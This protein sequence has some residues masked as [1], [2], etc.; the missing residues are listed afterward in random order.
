VRQALGDLPA[1]I[2]V[3]TQAVETLRRTENWLLIGMV[4]SKLGKAYLEQTKLQEAIMMLEQAL[5]IF[6]KERHADHESRALGAL[7]AAYGEMQQWSKSQEYREQALTLAREHG[8]QSE[9]AA[10]LPALAHL[11]EVQNDR[12]GAVQY[13]RQALHMAYVLEDPGLQAEYTFQLGR[14]LIDD[15]RTLMQAAQLL[16]ESDSLAPNGEA[17]RLLSRADKRLER[18]N[19][20]GIELPPAERTNREYAAAAYANAGDVVGSPE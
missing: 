2:E 3:Y 5:A 1:A 8:N 6:R 7:G 4:M 13:Y 10:Q 19:A 15:T 20:A 11:R 17:R 16:R 18:T 12:P 14:L 9:E